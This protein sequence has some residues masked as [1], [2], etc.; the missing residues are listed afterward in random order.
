MPGQ[1]PTRS[2]LFRLAAIVVLVAEV[3]A[4]GLAPV[5]EGRWSP[6]FPTHIEAAGAPPH[7]GHHPGIC[8]FCV[9]RH[10]SPLPA[11]S[12]GTQRHE[13][14]PQSIRPEVQLVVLVV[15]HDRPDPARAPP[16]LPVHTTI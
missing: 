16:A 5:A 13:M 4:F 1:P 2:A 11:H 10:F 6:D 15:G 8:T 9:L 14:P 7:A 12:R 3:V